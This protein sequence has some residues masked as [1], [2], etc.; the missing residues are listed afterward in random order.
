MFE[1][2]LTQILSSTKGKTKPYNLAGVLG[3]FDFDKSIP[4]FKKIL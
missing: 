4:V 1:K 2:L 3:W